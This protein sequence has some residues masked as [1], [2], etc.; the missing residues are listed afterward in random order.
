MKTS[1]EIIGIN[2]LEILN[3]KNLKQIDLANVMNLPKQTINKI[4]HG[5]KNISAQ[6]LLKIA[7]A[8]DVSTEEL[9]REKKDTNL[10]PVTLFM[11]QVNT[12]EARLGLK[13][14]QKIMDMIVFNSD[15]QQRKAVLMEECNL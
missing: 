11:G 10:E 13:H 12:K 4:I 15:I 1:N 6:E 3:R 8:L 9:I 14:A 7:K 5:R 2:I